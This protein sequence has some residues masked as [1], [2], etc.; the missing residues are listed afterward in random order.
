MSFRSRNYQVYLMAV[1]LLGALVIS[2]QRKILNT[3]LFPTV[4]TPGIMDM[5]TRLERDVSRGER[6][7]KILTSQVHSKSLNAFM[8]S[9]AIKDSLAAAIGSQG[10]LDWHSEIE[11]LLC[12]FRNQNEQRITTTPLRVDKLHSI[13]QVGHIPTVLKGNVKVTRKLAPKHSPVHHHYYAYNVFAPGVLPS[14]ENL[15]L[16][17]N[18][19]P[20]QFWSNLES[21]EAPS[22][23]ARAIVSDMKTF[24]KPDLVTLQNLQSIGIS[25]RD[26]TKT[27]RVRVLRGTPAQRQ[28]ALN[29]K[30]LDTNLSS[31]SG[32]AVAAHKKANHKPDAAAEFASETQDV[33]HKLLLKS[34]EYNS[35]LPVAVHAPITGRSTK[36]LKRRAKVDLDAGLI[37]KLNGQR[38]SCTV[39]ASGIQCDIPQPTAPTPS[40]SRS[41]PVQSNVERSLRTSI[42][43]GIPL[44][45]EELGFEC[46]V[47]PHRDMD[48][49]P[50]VK[51]KAF[52]LLDDALK[53]NVN[54]VASPAMRPVYAPLHNHGRD[55]PA[56]HEHLADLKLEG[57]PQLVDRIRR[58]QAKL[59]I[60]KQEET[61][62]REHARVSEMT[63]S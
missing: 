29:S 20:S 36:R 63:P 12:K 48:G 47:A 30:N 49:H 57:V 24:H 37:Q 25:R 3:E 40:L 22:S 18:H 43:C 35:H 9:N 15:H 32:L 28:T 16:M 19:R 39:G 41:K 26:S 52:N 38:L 7:L 56:S 59:R 33:L 58:V 31:D 45:S 21:Y 46:Q 60:Y 14:T 42:G 17:R 53:D 13:N 1:A 5:E 8:E 6:Q 34:H 62:Q 61:A 11:A 50:L 2:L 54:T 51:S 23:S 44:L 4:K 10:K 27:S 55:P